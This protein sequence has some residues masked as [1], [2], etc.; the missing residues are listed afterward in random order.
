M[1]EAA[2]SGWM[3][4]CCTGS[5]ADLA[6]W[7]R[8][9]DVLGEVSKQCGDSAECF[10]L[11]SAYASVP[12]RIHGFLF[13]QHPAFL[14]VLPSCANGRNLGVSRRHGAAVWPRAPGTVNVGI[15]AG[16]ATVDSGLANYER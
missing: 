14:S 5:H 11:A 15:K 16:H 9:V 7:D 1:T 13:W 10:L 4:L 2:H 12:G 8:I 6:T 3:S